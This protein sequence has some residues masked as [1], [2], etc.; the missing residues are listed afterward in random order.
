MHKPRVSYFFIFAGKFKPPGLSST[1]KV[2]FPPP[3]LA[4]RLRGD[5]PGQKRFL[6]LASRSGMGVGAS[7]PEVVMKHTIKLEQQVMTFDGSQRFETVQTW[8]PSDL[9]HDPKSWHASLD[10]QWLPEVQGPPA[11]P[12]PETK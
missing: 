8:S 1:T 3:R 11:P 7:N 6:W 4:P 9:A 12:I 5:G 2:S 10:G